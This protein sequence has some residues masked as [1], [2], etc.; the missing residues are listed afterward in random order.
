MRPHP[1][2]ENDW[3]VFDRS[4]G[5]VV[6][7]HEYRSAHRP[8][9][10]PIKPASVG[11][12]V[13]CVVF[14]LT[15]TVDGARVFW[16]FR[17]IFDGLI[18]N[19]I[20]TASMWY[21]N[22]WQ[23]WARHFEAMGLPPTHLRKA[24]QPRLGGA[25]RHVDPGPFRIFPEAS[26]SS[27]GL[28]ALLVRFV[29]PTRGSAA[30][31][32][33]ERLA[34][35]SFL[36]GLM[37]RALENAVPS[38]RMLRLYLSLDS[39]EFS[40]PLAGCRPIELVMDGSEVDC[41]PLDA[42]DDQVFQ[43]LWSQRTWKGTSVG[44]LDMLLFFGHLGR[45][46][47]V[48]FSQ[49]LRF[50]GSLVERIAL[51]SP[52]AR[53]AGESGVVSMEECVGSRYAKEKKHRL[54]V[55]QRQLALRAYV[56]KDG[57][58]QLLQYFCA[59]RECFQG[60]Q[61]VSA[62]FDASRVGGRSTLVGFVASTQNRG[63]WLPPQALGAPSTR[64]WASGLGEISQRTFGRIPKKNFVRVSARFFRCFGHTKFSTES[65]PGG[66]GVF[67]PFFS[68][69]STHKEFPGLAAKVY[70][71]ARPCAPQ[72]MKDMTTPV[73]LA[74]DSPA[75]TMTAALD[76]ATQQWQATAVEFWRAHT[77][78]A[79][80]RPQSAA[81]LQRT[82]AWWWL[83][84]TNHQLQ[85]G[86]G[87]NWTF[88]CQPSSLADRG[89]P[90]TWPGVTVSIDQGSDG[91]AAV[92][93]LAFKLECNIMVVHDASHRVWND[94]AG[95]IKRVRLWP[96]CLVG[97]ILLN[98][99]VGPWNSSKWWAD[100]VQAVSEYCAV[101]D[102][103][104]P[105][106]AGLFEHMVLEL[107]L[108][109]LRGTADFAEVVF[110]KVVSAFQTKNPRVGMTR[111]FAYIDSMGRFC[112]TWSCRLCVYFY[113]CAQLGLLRTSSLVESMKKKLSLRSPADDAEKASTS[114]DKES[115]RA[116]R[117][118]CRNTVEFAASI[119][120]DRELWQVQRGITM[121]AGPIRE[122]HGDQNQKNRSSSGS[123]IW[124]MQMSCGAG[125]R[126]IRETVRLMQDPPFWEA[127]GL[128]CH[129]SRFALGELT[130]QHP[131]VASDD[132]VFSK[133]AGLALAL[134]E[135]RAPSLAWHTDGYPGVFAGLLDPAKRVELLERM[136]FD[137]LVWDKW[138]EHTSP[139]WRK[140]AVRSSMRLVVT[141]QI[142]AVAEA[143][144][145]CRGEQLLGP[146]SQGKINIRL[147]RFA[148]GVAS[149]PAAWSDPMGLSAST[150]RVL[151]PNV[152]FHAGG[153]RISDAPPL[154]RQASN[155]EV[156]DE[157]I[158]LVRARVCGVT[159]TKL[160]EDAMR[161]E[162][163]GEISKNFG[164]QMS[165][166]RS[167]RVLLE[168]D[169][170]HSVHRFDR[171]AWE[172][173]TVP[174]GLKDQRI[175]SLFTPQA[176]ES[177]RELRQI[178]GSKTPDWNSPSPQVSFAEPEDFHLARH[179]FK[180]N[181]WE[182][183]PQC[184]L[185]TVAKGRQLMVR[186][187]QW[188]DGE[189]VFALGSAGGVCS[190]GWLAK[191]VC[192][193]GRKFYTPDPAGDYRWLLILDINDWL[194]FSYSWRSPLH[195][196]AL[197]GGFLPTVGFAEPIC[198][199]QPLMMVAA[200]FAFWDTPKLGLMQ[201]LRFAGIPVNATDALHEM[202]EKL[203]QRYLPAATDAEL[204]EILRLRLRQRDEVSDFLSSPEAQEL[205]DKSDHAD[206]AK[207]QEIK[208]KE[209]LSQCG[210]KAH[211]AQLAQKVYRKG[212]ARGGAR[213]SG[214]RGVAP[215]VRRYP[216]V[217]PAPSDAWTD[218]DVRNLCPPG[219]HVLA[220]HNNQRWLFTFDGVRKSRSWGCYGHG[221]SAL[222][223]IQMAWQ[224]WTD[225]GKQPP[226]PIE[227]LLAARLSA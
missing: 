131:A 96:T 188:P 2:R 224:S 173:Q 126:P 170:E 149:S 197:A 138:Q 117:A 101:A 192:V 130:P 225:L 223:L 71:A 4:L 109:H 50:A 74:L 44:F 196:A 108:E 33:N 115:V 81:K 203:V 18:G 128:S 95:A 55:F 85:A 160:I 25:A 190:L 103:T 208:N 140:K 110:E 172:G 111:W 29:K 213:N 76:D 165:L 61:F 83:V 3:V 210:L 93:F 195:M 136:K 118:M 10:V 17:Q 62:A 60:E 142:F 201:H 54:G 91:W 214:E 178:I 133:I 180:H 99:D 191:E 125:L 57:G 23:W 200:R 105:I 163:M 97:I 77:T 32:E 67:F 104:C 220:D 145:L 209:V 186:S 6:D 26:T 141:Q 63:M 135:T 64:L 222:M 89:P 84:A 72:A 45:P 137:K 144:V 53:T 205:I 162:R 15:H 39:Q 114:E 218:A 98:L 176:K 148:I 88:W 92:N 16:A 12:A 19:C 158:H 150:V 193:D 204:L 212:A 206:I 87:R 221:V 168:S 69:L 37:A 182:L 36:R 159:Q 22:W 68:A 21:Q 79:S 147:G 116:A 185:C 167:W 207:E 65:E 198:E 13:T 56:E 175:D 24:V 123:G 51:P 59:G 82:K 7:L 183:A 100:A 156:S 139:F 20:K 199:L 41:A 151:E 34:W 14:C 124:M 106:F 181:C 161:H 43:K 177:P 5:K 66:P 211:V 179:C 78:V 49:V 35:S 153:S 164:R 90:S 30:K 171:L 226:C 47:L 113:M 48:Y 166:R 155:W 215:F 58:R 1:E 28:V 42:L 40:L 122:W 46:A 169:L 31:H 194:G 70:S 11:E 27:W 202:L 217:I 38:R 8:L 112:E 80:E 102:T 174:R 127:L 187:V 86:V 154:H 73:S 120:T 219:T 152:Y 134:L 216:R 107:Q 75:H 121:I 157:L 146:G 52:P 132:E 227:G 119:M 184:W 129:S 189:Y 143:V 94:V 9:E